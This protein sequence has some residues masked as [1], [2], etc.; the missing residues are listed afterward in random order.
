[1]IYIT[2]TKRGLVTHLNNRAKRRYLRGLVC[3]KCGRKTNALIYYLQQYLGASWKCK[4]QHLNF[5]YQANHRGKH[6]PHHL[7]FPAHLSYEMFD[8]PDY[9][10]SRIQI[11]KVIEKNNL[12]NDLRSI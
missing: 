5:V 2:K 9:G 11:E 4:C 8:E 6:F 7:T 3:N 1:M 12:L 10:L